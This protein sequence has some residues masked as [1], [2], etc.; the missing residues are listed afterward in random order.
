ML[1][2]FTSYGEVAARRQGEIIQALRAG[3]SSAV[4]TTT[5]EMAEAV[6]R[7]LLAI[8]LVHPGK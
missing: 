2:T 6:V 8:G 3:T 5:D 1:T 7:K 4:G